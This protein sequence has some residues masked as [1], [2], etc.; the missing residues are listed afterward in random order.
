MSSDMITSLP[1]D[2]AAQVT[3]L[4]SSSGCSRDDALRAVLRQSQEWNDAL[5]RMWSDQAVLAAADLQLS[6]QQDERLSE[7]LELQQASTITAEERAE[8]A[9]QMEIFKA[10]QLHKARGMVE[11][12]RRGL[13]SAPAL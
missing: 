13:R 3:A 12:V 4:A 11:A 8:L 10:A 7:L 6:P 1:S 2:F 9:N 5:V